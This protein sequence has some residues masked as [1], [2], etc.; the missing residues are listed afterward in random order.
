MLFF[1]HFILVFALTLVNPVFSNGGPVASNSH[2]PV[3]SIVPL[4]RSDVKL[5]KEKLAIKLDKKD[6]KVVA[7]YNLESDKLR[8]VKFGVPL[9]WSIDDLVEA[10]K[11]SLPKSV[12]YKILA[13]SIELDINKSAKFYC[14]PMVPNKFVDSYGKKVS[15][16][17]RGEGKNLISAW[18]VTTLVVPRGESILT[19]K[20]RG[21]YAFQDQLSP[22]NPVVQY[23]RRT[24]TYPFSP[25]GY[26]A[27]PVESIS[28]SISPGPLV[29]SSLF[30]LDGFMFNKKNGTFEK[31]MKNVDFKKK[32]FLEIGIPSKHL[33]VDDLV[34]WNRAAKNKYRVKATASS[35][36]AKHPAQNILDGDPSTAW[37]EGVRG[38]GISEKITFAIDAK[39]GIPC[40]LF[41]VAVSH[42]YLKSQSTYI[43]NGKVSN[44]SL[45]SCDKKTVFIRNQKISVAKR[46]DVAG[47]YFEFPS[48][49]QE[50]RYGKLCI[51]LDI[52]QV[53]KGAKFQDTCISEVAFLADCG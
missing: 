3:G 10:D 5:R 41:G 9:S 26:W 1:R 14:K 25:A 46:F 4:Q 19:M 44:F 52:N 28:V 18:C 39:M 47:D 37:C 13:K 48:S 49:L 12:D 32:P 40:R 35:S 34:K 17:G 29:S 8:R 31:I 2:I 15:T 50:R 51:E 20:Y 38:S 45:S 7:Q 30:G 6:Y 16:V 22:G 53:V 33:E 43:E 23:G 42:G 11:K 24:L 36:L 21:G 27:G